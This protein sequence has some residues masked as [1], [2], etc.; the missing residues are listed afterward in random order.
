MDTFPIARYWFFQRL[1]PTSVLKKI[2][3]EYGNG[4]LQIFSTGNSWSLYTEEKK[5]VYAC[6]HQNM[7]NILIQKIK[8]LS[9]DNIHINSDT[10]RSRLQKVLSSDGAVIPAVGDG[11]SHAVGDRSKVFGIGQVK[12]ESLPPQ[13]YLAICWLVNNKYI[14]ASFAGLLIEE[15][16]LDIIKSLLKI[17]QGS[18]E[19]TQESLLSD[20][21]KFRYV[22]WRL[23]IE[24]SKNNQTLVDVDSFALN[25][26][27]HNNESSINDLS[28]ISTIP[29]AK[30]D[31]EDC[32]KQK[33]LVKTPKDEQEQL[34]EVPE[35]LEIL[36]VPEVPEVPEVIFQSVE[37]TDATNKNLQADEVEIE[38]EKEEI[39]KEE[40]E[41]TSQNQILTIK[42]IEAVDSEIVDKQELQELTSEVKQIKAEL[43]DK[44]QVDNE[45]DAEVSETSIDSNDPKIDLTNYVDDIESHLQHTDTHQSR[46]TQ[47][48][49]TK[50]N[51][52][53]KDL[54]ISQNSVDYSQVDSSEKANEKAKKFN[55]STSSKPVNNNTKSNN[56]KNNHKTYTIVCIDDSPAVLSAIKHYLDDQIFNVVDVTDPLKALTQIIR[57]KPHIILLDIGMPTLDGYELCSLLRK[58]YYF[59]HTPVIMVTGRTGFIDRAKAKLVKASGYLT[60]PFDKSDLL[61]VVFQ[62]IQVS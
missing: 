62:N 50:N 32:D 18:Y 52:L 9:N 58:H 40:I 21:P 43:V 3:T 11:Q 25:F 33:K 46:K 8:E 15:I 19:F 49:D 24:R 2:N 57:V 53:G 13:D 28:T 34:K 36:E 4:H 54:G 17:Q 31:E 29:E 1:D 60:K 35:I 37:I 42:E 22:D 48:I 41:K 47:N 30:L 7:L 14:T 10:I 26:Q 39:E 38:T 56:Q 16:S 20:L 12:G 44:E 59:K 51:I 6:Y 61:K 23:L 5:I 45:L 55:V 27:K